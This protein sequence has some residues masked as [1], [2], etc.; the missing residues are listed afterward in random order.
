MINTVIITK[1]IF[2]N[3]IIFSIFLLLSLKTQ[4]DQQQLGGHGFSAVDP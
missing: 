4:K 2:R 3:F 1:Y